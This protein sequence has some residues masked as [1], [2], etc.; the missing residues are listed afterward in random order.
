[1]TVSSGCATTVVTAST[2]PNLSINFW[3]PVAYY[4]STGAAFTDFTDTI[5]TSSGVP[6]MCFKDYTATILPTTLATFSLD[7]NTKEFQVFSG[8]YAQIGFVYTVTL[9]GTV[10]EVPTKFA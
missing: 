3:D 8:S 10:N 6:D 2:A 9:K 7:T 1:L 4:P 5:S